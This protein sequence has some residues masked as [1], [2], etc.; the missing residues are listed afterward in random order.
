MAAE[1]GDGK[2]MFGGNELKGTV[3]EGE[4]EEEYWNNFSK[5]KADKQA[6][7]AKNRRGAKVRGRG[8]GRN[9]VTRGE[10]VR[11][12]SMMPFFHREFK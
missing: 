6:R 3:L 9:G 5:K 7:I 10:K 12:S 11:Q 1:K 8:R 2:V 4:E